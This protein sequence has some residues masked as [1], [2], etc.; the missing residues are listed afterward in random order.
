MPRIEIPM[1]LLSIS[2]NALL[3]SIR[4][5]VF[6][7]LLIAGELALALNLSLAAFTFGEDDKLLVDLGLSTL[8]L[9]G[10]LSAA[11]TAASVLANEIEK[12]TVLTVVS[13]PVSRAT[14]VLGKFLGVCGALAVG[15]WTL[16]SVFLLTVRH[17]VAADARTDIAFD[18]PV[19]IVST[20][21]FGLAAVYAGLANYLYRRPFPSVFTVSTAV[22]ATAAVV[23]TWCIEPSWRFQNPSREWNP[24]LMFALAMVFEAVLVLA[25]VAMAASTRLGQT[26]TFFVSLG[27]LL[28][29]L[30]GEY[31]V[32][33]FAD[34]ERLPNA[35]RNLA[36]LF[37][38]IVPN[39]QYFWAADALT[40]GHPIT[41]FY[42]YTVSAYASFMIA[43]IMSLAVLL[44]QRRDV[45]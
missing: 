17:G 45:G 14:V 39:L 33:Q 38:L 9:A 27:F 1:T 16:S 30:V 28:A 3:E 13:K 37:V 36:G 25:A 21:F 35:V 5:P 31:F 23:T 29:G 11:F 42:F 26:A 32:G 15:Q 22:A 34:T 20:L 8:L 43:G 19:I 44:F 2:R 24:Q 4:Q 12:R 18:M 40:Q 41:P 7:V 10:L 6:V